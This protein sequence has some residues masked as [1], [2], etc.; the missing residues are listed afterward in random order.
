MRILLINHYAGSHE[1]GMNFRPYYLAKNWL[2][3]G[4]SVS[5]V[6]SS[7]SHSRIKQPKITGLVSREKISNID[8]IWLYGNRYF[9]NGIGRAVNIL[10]F[11]FQS[12]FLFFILRKP[13]D[14]ILTSSTF[15]LDIFTAIIY[16][17][18]QQV[19]FRSKKSIIIFEPHDLWPMA[20]TEL[21]KMSKYNPFVVLNSIGEKLSITHSSRIISM[22]PGNI[23]HLAKRGAKKHNFHYIPNGVNIDDWKKEIE[24]DIKIKKK[25]D[26]VKNYNNKIIMY[27][28]SISVA[29]DIEILMES[30]KITNM[31][32]EYVIVGHGHML[33]KYKK[34]VVDNNLP[35]H[36]IGKVSKNQ[37]PKILSY[38]DI[39]YVGFKNSPLLK[40]GVGANKIWDYMMSGKPIIMSVNSCNDPIKEANCGQTISNGSVTNLACVLDKFIGLD[41][42]KLEKL[43]QN[44]KDFVLK[45]NTYDV[46]A[47]KCIN[48]FEDALKEVD[49]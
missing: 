42:E 4:H 36:F 24:P 47:S 2:K 45:N 20:L 12:L 9:G 13:Y 17:N 31:K 34:Y 27:T 10:L 28:G 3:M 49:N 1:L 41:D 18:L 40:Y 26:K 11:V 15:T 5:I 23:D 35:F 39:C 22:H 16:K 38:A 33:E 37:I 19:F 8:Y 30:S 14:V 29:N 21:G 48:I 43:G 6:G 44:A 32:A 7:Y 46:L 25:L